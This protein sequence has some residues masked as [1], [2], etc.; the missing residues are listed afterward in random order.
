MAPKD[1][2][3][4]VGQDEDLK[5]INSGDTAWMLISAA[6]V[7]IMTPGVAFFYGELCSAAAS[8][9]RLSASGPG[10]L[11]PNCLHLKRTS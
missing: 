4:G 7:M 1:P 2:V 11:L 3:T 10:V 5:K 6:I 8:T 9:T